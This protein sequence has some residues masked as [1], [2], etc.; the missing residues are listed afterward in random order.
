MR[1]INVNSAYVKIPY[2][3]GRETTASIRNFTLCPQKYNNDF[4]SKNTT[5]GKHDISLQS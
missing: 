4:S 1:L 2:P 3:S 5:F